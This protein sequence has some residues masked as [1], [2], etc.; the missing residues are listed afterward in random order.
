MPLFD[1]LQI[2]KGD[3]TITCRN[4]KRR[5]TVDPRA[6]QQTADQHRCGR[7]TKNAGR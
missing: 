7:T 5:Y 3:V 1:W 2:G 6:M 4:C